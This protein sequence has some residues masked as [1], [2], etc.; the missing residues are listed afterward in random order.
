MELLDSFLGTYRGQLIETDFRAGCP[1]VAI[2]VEAGEPGSDL[3]ERAGAAFARWGEVLAGRLV[4]E[5]VQAERAEE[6]AMMVIASVEGALV[7]ARAR[8]DA[9][10]L[11]IVHRQLRALLLAETT[12]RRS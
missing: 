5:G 3:Q 10:P 6:L 11:D 1:V 2:A 4:A 7:I 8:R 9:E 12:D